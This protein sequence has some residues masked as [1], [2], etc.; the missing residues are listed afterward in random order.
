MV[1]K[2]AL[3]L[4]LLFPVVANAQQKIELTSK[5]GITVH[6]WY[7]ESEESTGAI[8]LFHQAGSNALAEYSGI[9][10][11][12]V[13][14]GYSVLAIDQRKGGSRLGGENLTSA[15]VDEESLSYCDAYPDLEVATNYLNERSRRK[16]IVWGSSYSAALVLKLSIEHHDQVM[17]VLA[18]SPASGG[19]MGECSANQFI[20]AL[21][22][23][24]L[25]LRPAREA[26]IE[27]VRAQLDLFEE[28]GFET[29]ISPEGVHG[30]SM[31]NPDRAADAQDTWAQVLNFLNTIE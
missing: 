11:R 16:I 28:Q 17:A 2:K 25:A 21:K 6:G 7:Y 13:E 4:I 20:E 14:A 19:P 29:Y 22:V 26:E 15:Q 23:P 3:F 9:A 18:F 31:L 27:S 30:S 5:D 8:A 1:S 24:T 12:L 10:A